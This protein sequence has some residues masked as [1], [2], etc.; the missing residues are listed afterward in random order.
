LNCAAEKGVKRVLA[1]DD[2]NIIHAA[3]KGVK[4]F[5]RRMV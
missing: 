5:T 2:L 3:E 1:E 4:E